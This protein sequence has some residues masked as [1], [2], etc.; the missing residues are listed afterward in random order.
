LLFQKLQL[1][2]I[3]NKGSQIE[4]VPSIF[5]TNSGKPDFYQIFNEK[6]SYYGNISRRRVIEKRSSKE[7]SERSINGQALNLYVEY[8][9]VMDST[10]YR[11]FY[12]IYTQLDTQLMFQNLKVFYSHLVFGVIIEICSID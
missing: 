12:D 1:I 9:V 2:T 7:R 3:N 4:F 6:K 5:K 8:L 10:A 11:K